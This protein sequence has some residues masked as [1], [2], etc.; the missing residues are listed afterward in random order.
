MHMVIIMEE[1]G[2]LCFKIDQFE[3]VSNGIKDG[4]TPVFIKK[5]KHFLFYSFSQCK[6]H[7]KFHLT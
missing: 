3:N 1:F 6:S 7:P 5:E 2:G 4:S